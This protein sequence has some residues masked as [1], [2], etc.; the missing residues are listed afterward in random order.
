MDF[1]DNPLMTMMLK[2][3]QNAS[4]SLLIQMFGR[5]HKLCCI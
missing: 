2:T 4:L 5:I 1:I 3:E